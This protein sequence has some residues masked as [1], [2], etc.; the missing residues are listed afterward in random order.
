MRQLISVTIIALSLIIGTACT[1]PGKK[2]AI[3]AGAGAAGGALLGA[4]IGHQSGN[5]GKG[6]LIGA[7]A[8]ATVG[9]LVGNRLDKQAKELSQLAETKRTEHGI[10]TKLKNDILFDSGSAGLKAEAQQKISQIGAVIKKYPEDIVTVI[11][12]TDNVGKADY[13]QQLS[14]NRAKAVKL[15]LVASGVPSD[16]VQVVGMGPSQPLADNKS[17][18]GRATNRRVELQ[19]TV[20]ESK[21]KK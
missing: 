10:V 7:A 9:G 1:S 18:A 16:N 19:I 11:G 3:G 6:A 8:G 20:D 14:E 21:V 13:N 5:S 12:H 17:P 2:T 15:Q 4:V